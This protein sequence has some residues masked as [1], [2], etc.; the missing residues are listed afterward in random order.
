MKYQLTQEQYDN[1]QKVINYFESGELKA[2]FHMGHFSD[3]DSILGAV[4]CGTNGCIIGHATFV[5]KKKK[6]ETWLN[7][8]IRCFGIE[9]L[10]SERLKENSIWNKIFDSEWFHKDNTV[11]GAI[12]RMKSFLEEVDIK[13]SQ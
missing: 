2:K 6:V 8:G 10:E 3:C 13:V 7:F 12:Q 11:H 9:K 4:E 1:Y 5:V